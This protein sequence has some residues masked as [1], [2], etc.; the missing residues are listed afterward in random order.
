MA[1]KTGDFSCLSMSTSKSMKSG[2]AP[3]RAVDK[4]T[5]TIDFQLIVHRCNQ[6]FFKETVWQQGLLN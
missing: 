3:Y 4:D 1:D 6:I 2:N 5:Q